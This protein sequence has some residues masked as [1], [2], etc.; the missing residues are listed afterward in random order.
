MDAS[1]TGSSALHERVIES[2]GAD[3]ASGRLAPGSRILTTEVAERFGVSRSA[4]REVVRV[5]ESM[6]LVAVRRRAG[7]EILP[8]A[9]W[10]PYSTRLLR[11]R[12][13]GP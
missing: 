1:T 7:V 13:A 5:L 8:R 2:I 4:M 12:L 10:N 6:G 11:W 9:R 3:I